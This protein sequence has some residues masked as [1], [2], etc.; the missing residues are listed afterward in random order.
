MPIHLLV[1]PVFAT[2]LGGLLAVRWRRQIHVLLAVAAGL[3]LG[4]AFLDLL[5]EAVI[6]GVQ[7]NI[8]VSRIFMLTLL[9]F[10]AFYVLESALDKLSTGASARVPRKSIGRIAGTMLI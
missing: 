1:L 7:G 6:L 9:S 4:A 2:L 8:A 5:P 10:L 3:L